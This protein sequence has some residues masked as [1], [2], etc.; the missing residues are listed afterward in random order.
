MA[1]T[2]KKL[3]AP[4]AGLPIWLSA[5]L[6][7]VLLA[8]L[9]AVFAF[10][11]PLALF[12]AELP[13]IE[14]LAFQRINVLPN[15]FEFKVSNNGP[16]P[17]TIALSGRSASSRRPPSSAWARPPSAWTIRGCRPSRT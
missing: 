14:D 10:G 2:E 5:L 8:A 9:L 3:T 4:A 15:G 6:P 7:L 13:P 12:T 11:N 16:D 17:V 1:T